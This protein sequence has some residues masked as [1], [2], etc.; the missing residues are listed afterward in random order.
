MIRHYEYLFYVVRNGLCPWYEKANSWY[1]MA[2][3]RNTYGTK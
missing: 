1:G 2:M 3:V